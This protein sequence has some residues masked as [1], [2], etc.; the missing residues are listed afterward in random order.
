MGP[1]EG[2]SFEEVRARKQRTILRQQLHERYDQWR[3]A[4]EERLSEPQPTLSEGTQVV[5]ELQQGAPTYV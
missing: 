2:I 5:G 1:A 4:L 3:D